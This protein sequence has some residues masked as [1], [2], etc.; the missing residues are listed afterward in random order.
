MRQAGTFSGE[1]RSASRL[2]L[3][4]SAVA[5][6]GC[7]GARVEAVPAPTLGETAASQRE[8]LALLELFA[9]PARERRGE[10]DGKL[11]T[12]CGRFPSDPLGRVVRALRAVG[13]L[14]SGDFA[15]A[16]AL[17][18]DA[19][20]GP[21]GASRD[22]ATLVVGS[23]AR[24]TGRP[25]E[26]LELLTPLLHKLIEPFATELLDEELTRAALAA[27][28]GAAAL[29]FMR[30]W[31]A[32]VAEPERASVEIERLIG[33]LDKPSLFA[34][35]EGV[36]A[37]E[38]ASNGRARRQML[39]AMARR[40]A[41]LARE[42][43]DVALARL[44]LERY[45]AL[46]GAGGEGVAGLALDTA[47]ERVATSTVGLLLS[48]GSS[49]AERRS[50][51]VVAG[52]TFA[53]GVGTGARLVVRT[54]HMGEGGGGKDGGGKDSV[55]VALGELASEG[56][57]VILAGIDARHV[58]PAVRFSIERGLPVVLL[59]SDGSAAHLT[60][61]RVFLAGIEADLASAS[62]LAGAP[63]SVADGTRLD[64]WHDA[65]RPA[66]SWWTAV[67]RDA[68]TLA[69]VAAGAAPR[70]DAPADVRVS[71]ELAARALASARR[72]LWTTGE[73]GFGSDRRVLRAAPQ[74]EP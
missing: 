69:A 66:P 37:R 40:L 28:D 70:A 1:R 55:A 46:L 61:E 64:G 36:G 53:L 51:D 26:A 42:S 33:E 35:L 25:R 62:S 3:A 10:L 38:L 65:G 39:A 18:E 11:A 8:Y 24:R 49:D 6:A 22:L 50:A 47:R 57:A 12:F 56:A 72:P 71:R 43:N 13:A 54:D 15:R 21:P 59:S 52:V 63:P 5:F 23:V 20:R 41:E 30:I 74:V 19:L 9:A 17:A 14:D 32:E 67:A 16:S 34:E 68:A 29:R 45:E 31:L 60:A 48:V 73:Q 7:A 4:F 2:V 27:G 58:L 44:L